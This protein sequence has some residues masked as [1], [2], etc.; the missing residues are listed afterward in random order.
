[1]PTV[2][3]RLTSRHEVCD[4]DYHMSLPKELQPYGYYT[5]TILYK[6]TLWNAKSTKHRK[7]TYTHMY[8]ATTQ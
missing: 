7:E 4:T 5:D 6:P 2:Q 3:Y 1:M 8:S